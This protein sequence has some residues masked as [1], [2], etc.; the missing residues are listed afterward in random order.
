MKLN[1]CDVAGNNVSSAGLV[2]HATML[3]RVSSGVSPFLAEDPGNAN[4]DNDFRLT[5]SSYLVNLSTKSAGFQ[6]GQWVLSFTVN[7]VSHPSYGVS[8][9]IK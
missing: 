1:L 3:S 2:V 8:F 9:F 7:G 6:D 5:G 4:P